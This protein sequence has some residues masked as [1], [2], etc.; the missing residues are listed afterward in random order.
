MFSV[1]LK[2]SNLAKADKT[3]DVREN[4]KDVR[5]L[6]RFSAWSI[7]P[8]DFASAHFAQRIYITNVW[9]SAKERVFGGCE[10]IEVKKSVYTSQA[11]L[12]RFS[13]SIDHFFC[14]LTRRCFAKL[15]PELLSATSFKL[16]Q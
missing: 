12:S 1:S 16:H 6:D 9:T 13:G 7:D 4:D 2:L 15:D 14:H 5:E 11:C 10:K 8:F 3:V